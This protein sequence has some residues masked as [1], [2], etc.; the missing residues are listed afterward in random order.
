VDGSEIAQARGKGAQREAVG[1]GADAACVHDSD[2]AGQREVPRL[3]RPCIGGA[4]A[5]EVETGAPSGGLVAARVAI[6]DG[7]FRP[8]WLLRRRRRSLRGA[9]GGRGDGQQQNECVFAPESH[10][11]LLLLNGELHGGGLDVGSAG[12]GDGDCVVLRRLS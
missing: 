6:V 5:V 9:G 12:A 11:G 4:E 3:Y 8:Q 1:G 7:K 2:I 10:V